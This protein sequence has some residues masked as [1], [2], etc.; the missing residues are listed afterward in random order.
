MSNDFLLGIDLGGTKIYAVVADR[1][2][3]VLSSAKSK[4]D[5]EADPTKLG[6]MIK[7]TGTEALEALKLDLGKISGIGVAVPSSVDPQS[8]DCLH[9]PNLGLKNFSLK[10]ILRKLFGRE[11]YLGNDANCGTLAEYMFGA[12][13]GYPSVLAYFLGTGLGGGIIVDGKLLLGNGGLAGELGHSLIKYKGRRCACGNRGC[14]E[15]YCSKIAFVKAIK[16]EVF[17]KSRNCSLTKDKLEWS[18]TNIRSKALAQAYK[19]G[20]RVVR[21]VLD[22]G[23]FMLGAAAASASTVIAPHCIVLGGG[24]IESMGT[25]L[26]PPFKAS[27]EKH[28]FGLDPSRIELR[29]SALGDNAVALGACILADKKAKV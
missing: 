13:K 16:K 24:V 26:M 19:S 20:D 3:K 8:G 6:T 7:E 9:A 23:M 27:F 28:L 4:T 12:A 22:K 2:G 1:D 5:V 21:K 18:T 10:E 14:V 15:A 25:E 11:L 29:L 17:K